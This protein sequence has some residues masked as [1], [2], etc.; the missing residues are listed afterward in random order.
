[1]KAGPKMPFCF[2]FSFERHP[3]RLPMWALM[4]SDKCRIIITW[5]NFLHCCNCGPV[6]DAGQSVPLSK[7]TLH[8]PLLWATLRH[9]YVCPMREV[10]RGVP[11]ATSPHH[12]PSASP[13]FLLRVNLA[14]RC[15][16]D[17]LWVHIHSHPCSC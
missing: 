12:Y 2:A 8:K 1:M 13:V 14:I 15:P 16:S 3:V 4:L 10:V 7:P 17:R 5:Q 6:R 9:S 11:Q